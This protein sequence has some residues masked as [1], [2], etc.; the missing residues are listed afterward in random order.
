MLHLHRARAVYRKLTVANWAGKR[1]GRNDCFFHASAR[2]FSL[3]LT[4]LHLAN[5]ALAAFD[6]NYLLK[7]VPIADSLGGKI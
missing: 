6:L 3:C 7:A 2:Q 4:F 1:A 5:K